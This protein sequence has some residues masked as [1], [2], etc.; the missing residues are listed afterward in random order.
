[1]KPDYEEIR[2]SEIEVIKNELNVLN[3]GSTDNDKVDELRS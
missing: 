3:D 2:D 1:M